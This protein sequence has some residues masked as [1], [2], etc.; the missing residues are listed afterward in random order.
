M[1]KQQFSLS[2]FLVKEGRRD[3]TCSKDETKLGI[4]IADYS[5]FNDC[6]KEEN[7]K[8]Y[9]KGKASRPVGRLNGPV[10]NCA[11]CKKYPGIK[12]R[13]LG[14]YK[15]GHFKKKFTSRIGLG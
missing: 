13:I 10:Y 3:L 9:K 6:I 14:H 7:I 5:C 1:T 12:C 11:F 2:D 15:D 4:K 8:D